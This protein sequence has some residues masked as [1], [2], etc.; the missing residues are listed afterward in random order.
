MHLCVC[1]WLWQRFWR[2]DIIKSDFG[3]FLIEIRL[4]CVQMPVFS[5]ENMESGVEFRFV[6]Y[7][8]NGKG[9]SEPFILDGITFRGVAKY[10]GTI[11]LFFIPSCRCSLLFAVHFSYSLHKLEWI[12]F[13]LSLCR[14][15]F[16]V[17]FLVKK[18]VYVYFLATYESGYTFSCQAKYYR[19]DKKVKISLHLFLLLAW[20]YLFTLTWKLLCLA[21]GEW[22]QFA[23][24][25]EQSC[26]TCVYICRQT[27]RNYAILWTA[28][29]PTVKGVL[30]CW[31][32]KSAWYPNLV[33]FSP[34]ILSFP[35]EQIDI[36]R[37]SLLPTKGT[38]VVTG[39]GGALIE[40]VKGWIHRGDFSVC[41]TARLIIMF[42]WCVITGKDQVGRWLTSFEFSVE[43]VF[44]KIGTFS[45]CVRGGESDETDSWFLECILDS[46]FFNFF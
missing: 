26:I 35:Y 13:L 40:N 12:L 16:F 8:V 42:T 34:F 45:I 38:L 5:V 3:H 28:E 22:K 4:V 9:R 29:W 1:V 15:S 23:S 10:T 6:V 46:F 43:Q 37:F 27:N 41:C 19:Q 18:A 14:C 36:S 7:A 33:L 31:K 21:L 44:N 20:G 24:S 32:E 11:L 25:L 17:I 30:L 2:D 39:G